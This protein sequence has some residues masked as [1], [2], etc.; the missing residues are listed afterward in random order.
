MERSLK[1]TVVCEWDIC[2]HIRQEFVQTTELPLYVQKLVARWSEDLP[3]PQ[4]Q[5]Q[6]QM[7]H[8]SQKQAVADEKCIALTH[9]ILRRHV[10]SVL[11]SWQQWTEEGAITDTQSASGSKVTV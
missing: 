5:F 7:C 3:L 6:L 10:V 11:Q 4:L 8:I 2:E 1:H 9:T